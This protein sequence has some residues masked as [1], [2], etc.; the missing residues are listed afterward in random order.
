MTR[1]LGTALQV[2][3]LTVLVG[4]CAP[5][6]DT[7]PVL[8]VINGKPL[9]Q[10]EFEYRWSSLP[11]PARQTYQHSGGKRQYLDDLVMEELLLQEARKL[12]LDRSFAVRERLERMKTQILL[13][14]VMKH[15]LKTTEQVSEQ[16]LDAYYATE[17]RALLPADRIHAA[18]IVVA[19]VEKAADLK[20]Q[21]ERGS[22]FTKAAQRHS[23]DSATRDRGGELGAFKPG[24]YA[25]DIE[26][27]LL[28]QKPGLISEPVK[29]NAGF[30][31]VK[32]TGR[33]PIDPALIAQI[34]ERLRHELLAEKHR[35]RVDDYLA[36][37]R[38]TAAI[39]I[40]ESSRLTAQEPEHPVES[41]VPATT[42]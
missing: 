5:P 38:A 42:Q 15:A 12:G 24:A 22:D 27:I 7:T 28:N 17:A 18:Q 30:H 4:A 19:T 10:E 26:Y 32:V 9:S 6:T 29:T 23:L 40:A 41:P 8:V 3:C 31:I 35:K 21:L 20:R 11:D 1:I 16:E 25:P 13:D 2:A 37:L 14:E 36:K 39:R 33:D 34:R